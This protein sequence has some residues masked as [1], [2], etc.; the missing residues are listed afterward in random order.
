MSTPLT[1][2]IPKVAIEV[3]G[4]ARDILIDAIRISC[5]TFCNIS[6]IWKEWLDPIQV[7]ATERVIEVEH[8]SDAR[9]LKIL[10]SR[11][12]NAKLKL[13][14]PNAADMM[15]PRWDIDLVGTPKVLFLR[16]DDEFR[17]APHGAGVLV[18]EAVLRPS[19]A[20]NSVADVLYT[21][22]VQAIANGAKAHLM[23]MANVPWSNPIRA[24]QLNAEFEHAM[25]VASNT[26][27]A[28]FV[29]APVRSTLEY[30]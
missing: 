12:N 3:P 8:P 27:A 18:V 5:T 23:A 15:Y 9:V 7:T 29:R 6:H 11:F 25:H 24:M 10:N 2:F 1:R 30:R 28:G 22:H 14:S 26:Q 4:A 13:I 17:L 19:E 16:S 21:S 20:A